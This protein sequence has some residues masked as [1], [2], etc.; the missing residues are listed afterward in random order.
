MGVP[1]TLRDSQADQSNLDPKAT[2]R[3]H[4]KKQTENKESKMRLGLVARGFNSHSAEME[5]VRVLWVQSHPA[6]HRE[7][8]A[9]WGYM[10]PCPKLKTDET[11]RWTMT[12]TKWH[13]GLFP[14]PH[15]PP[16]NC[17][18]MCTHSCI[19]IH[20]STD[21]SEGPQ[22]SGWLVLHAHSVVHVPQWWLVPWVA[23]R[24]WFFAVTMR[25]YLFLGPQLLDCF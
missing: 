8:Q 15:T 24:Y 23:H 11:V 4:F 14:G 16:H 18:H 9:D 22:S 7:F 10:K 3:L 6:P 20:S 12:D 5:A 25:L 17:T 2:G 19:C 21:P 1:G 13:W